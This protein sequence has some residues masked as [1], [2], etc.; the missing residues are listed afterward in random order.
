MEYLQEIHAHY[1]PALHV[2]GTVKHRGAQTMS[3]SNSGTDVTLQEE[4][5]NNAVSIGSISTHTDNAS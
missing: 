5:Q 3:E 4:K 1:R 2:T